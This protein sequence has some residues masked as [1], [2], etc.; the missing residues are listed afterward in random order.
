M[1]KAYEEDDWRDS[2]YPSE[3]DLLR[4]FL[5]DMQ[6]NVCLVCGN[7]LY[8]SGDVHEAIIKKGDLPADDR[9]NSEFNCVTLHRQCHKNTR[10]VDAICLAF[11]VWYHGA[12]KVQNWIRSLEMRNLPT[13][14][15]LILEMGKVEP[16]DS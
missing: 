12:R 9:V 15:R 11:L 16:D 2:E 10:E 8:G 7:G 6:S 1:S 3:R 13:R 14:A 5:E 4:Q